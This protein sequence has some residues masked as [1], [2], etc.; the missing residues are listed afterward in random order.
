MFYSMRS[1]NFSAFYYTTWKLGHRIN[2][3][4]SKNCNMV[5]SN[6]SCL[7]QGSIS[8]RQQWEWG[9]KVIWCCRWFQFEWPPPPILL[10]SFLNRSGVDATYS[11]LFQFTRNMKY[12]GILFLPVLILRVIFCPFSVLMT[13]SWPLAL[14]HLSTWDP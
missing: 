8:S 12:K 3:F 14:L 10:H 11:I 6:Q 2:R 9:T 13:L 7:G 4:H 1:E 5:F